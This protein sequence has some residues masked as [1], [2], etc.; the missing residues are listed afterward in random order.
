M[1]KTIFGPKRKKNTYVGLENARKEENPTTD[2]NVR[3]QSI[4][5]SP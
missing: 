5:L 1:A 4:N 2:F 3:D